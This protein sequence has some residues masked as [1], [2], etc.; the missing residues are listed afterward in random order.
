MLVQANAKRTERTWVYFGS[1]EMQPHK[2]M[3]ILGFTL[4]TVQTHNILNILV[5]TVGI[6]QTDNILNI[7]GLTV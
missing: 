2:F 6:V 5:F 4:G 3:N 1:T 7:L